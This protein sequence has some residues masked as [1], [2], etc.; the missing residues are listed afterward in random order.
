MTTFTRVFVNPQKRHGRKVLTNPEAMHAEVRGLFPPDLPSDNGRVLWRLDQHDNE[1][2]LYIV[3]P[4]RPDTAELADRLGWSTRPAQTADY[5]KLLSSLSKGQQWCFE[6]L[7]NPSISLKTGG[8]RGKSVP[9]ARI[10]QQID[11]L[12]QRSEK[13]GFKVLPQG[14][15]AESDL[16]IANR[17]VMR[18]SKN[19]RDHKRTVALTTVRFEGTLEVTDAEA[20]R[21]T[22]TQGI[23]KGRAYGLG[24]MTLARR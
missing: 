1:H 6:L 11:W 21:A 13:N 14:D 10:D 9:L 23:G 16:R 5:D 19:P 24:L 8:K 18:F 3:G 12:L 20:L 7:A 22:L 17:K 4:E 15:S 2:I